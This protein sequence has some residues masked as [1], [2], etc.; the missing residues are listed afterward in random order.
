MHQY[1]IQ[2]EINEIADNVELLEM[3]ELRIPVLKRLDTN[4]EI[5]WPFTIDDVHQF[6][7]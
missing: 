4:A 1:D 6:L 5:G 3:Y 2:Y 7:S